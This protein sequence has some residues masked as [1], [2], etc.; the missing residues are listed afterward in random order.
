VNS[1]DV[2]FIPSRREV[3]KARS[4]TE[5]RPKYSS[6]S[7]A[8]WLGLALVYREV[9]RMEPVGLMEGGEGRDDE[10]KG[11]EDGNLWRE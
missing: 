8:W 6:R 9:D 10:R 1:I 5:S 3:I 4:A 7:I 11:W 2:V